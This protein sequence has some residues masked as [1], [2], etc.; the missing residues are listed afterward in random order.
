M[1]SPLKAIHPLITQARLTLA[2]MVSL[3]K[4]KTH[5]PKALTVTLVGVLVLVSRSY[6]PYSVA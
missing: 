3:G 1:V 5:K 2:C 6:H 4:N